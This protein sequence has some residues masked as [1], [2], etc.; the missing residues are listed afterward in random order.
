MPREV[1]RTR[2]ASL[3]WQASHPSKN[4][5]STP[6]AGFD[7]SANPHNIPYPH[8]S[9]T[10]SDSASCSVA[11]KIV[12]AKSADSEVS[13]IHSNGIIMP[14][15]KSAHSHAARLATPNP[16]TRLPARKMGTQAAEEKRTFIETAAKKARVVKL[17][18][19][20]NIPA[21]NNE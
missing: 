11:H 4:G 9:R 10:R 21:N 13:Q 7:I 17:P 15:G 20:L 16:P 14:L 2:R 19:I 18:K 1:S 6:S 3:P 8:Q 5:S 12:A